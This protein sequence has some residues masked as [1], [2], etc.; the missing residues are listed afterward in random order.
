MLTRRIALTILLLT[1]ANTARSENGPPS[2]L[3]GKSVVLQYTEARSFEPVEPGLGRAHDDTVEFEA[4]IYISDRGRIFAKVQRTVHSISSRSF[5]LLKSPDQ[6]S[7]GS[8][9]IFEGELLLGL[10]KFGAAQN[11]AVKRVEVRFNVHSQSCAMTLA[12]ARPEGSDAKIFDGW[13]GER[14]Y[15]RRY[16]LTSSACEVKAGNVFDGAQ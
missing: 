5:D 13:H 14:Y 12:Y 9:W 8:D 3:L 7:E 6:T 4:T 10:N 15:L 1:P 11:A 2:W 16:R